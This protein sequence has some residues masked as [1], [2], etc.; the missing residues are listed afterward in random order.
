LKTFR[1]NIA[2]SI[3]SIRKQL[4]IPPK[5]DDISLL[6]TGRRKPARNQ[7]SPTTDSQLTAISP[8]ATKSKFNSLKTFTIDPTSNLY[9][10]WLALFSLSFLYNFVL[11]IMRAAFEKLSSDTNALVW[12]LID[13]AFCDLIYIFD[14]LIKLRTS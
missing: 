2:D 12:Y 8:P 1:N 10:Y 9:F 5:S 14:M 6:E 13:Y 11:L 3:A 7:V 4:K